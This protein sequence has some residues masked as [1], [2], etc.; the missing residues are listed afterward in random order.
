MLN[1]SESTDMGSE[2]EISS[3]MLR[4]W[5]EVVLAQFKGRKFVLLVER[6]LWDWKTSAYFKKVA[7]N[8]ELRAW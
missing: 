5:T 1:G 6:I 4:V 8:G 7:D 2:Y 3:L